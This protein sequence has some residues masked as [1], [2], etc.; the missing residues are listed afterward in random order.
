[1]AK[2]EP[3]AAFVT[4]LV[5]TYLDKRYSRLTLFLDNARTH[6]KKMKNLR[7][8]YLENFGLTKRME[9]EFV[10]IPSYSPAMN[11]AEYFIQII[12]K[13][14]LKNLPPNL[15]INQVV[16]QIIPYVQGQNLLNQEQMNNII[17]R[18]KRIIPKNIPLLLDFILKGF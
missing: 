18:V 17:A 4:S 12:R 7:A 10:H 8:Q 1:V 16:E 14:F 15:S 6:K 5:F 3:V 11:A 2:A 9:V 13:K